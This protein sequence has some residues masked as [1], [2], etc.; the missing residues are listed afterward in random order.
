M[1]IQYSFVLICVQFF[2]LVQNLVISLLL[3]GLEGSSIHVLDPIM[4]ESLQPKVNQ[5]MQ[6]SRQ[7]TYLLLFNNVRGHT[8]YL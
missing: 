1:L 8:A 4:K 2:N 7:K 6:P 5:V 3:N